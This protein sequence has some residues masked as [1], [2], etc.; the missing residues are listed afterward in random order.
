MKCVRQTVSACT[1]LSPTMRIQVIV[2]TCPVTHG[3]LLPT[4]QTNRRPLGMAPC[5]ADRHPHLTGCDQPQPQPQGQTNQSHPHP[6]PPHTPGIPLF[7]FTFHLP[8][9][10]GPGPVNHAGQDGNT[11]QNAAG[12]PPQGIPDFAQFLQQLMG[13]EGGPAMFPFGFHLPSFMHEEER[14]DPERATRLVNG[15]EIVP[16]GLVKRM[17]RV[18]G[19]GTSV[20]EAPVCAICWES[21][22]DPPGSD[23]APADQTESQASSE[24]SMNL[25]ESSAVPTNQPDSV[26]SSSE[27]NAVQDDRI[28]VLP[29]SHVFHASCLLPWFSKPHRTTCP[30]CRFDID[31]DSLTYVPRPR[32]SRRAAAGQAPTGPQ[33]QTTQAETGTQASPQPVPGFPLG[34]APGGAPDAG[35]GQDQNRAHRPPLSPF[36]AL[37]FSMFIPVGPIPPPPM[38]HGQAQAQPQPQARGQPQQPRAGPM[39]QFMRLDEQSTRALFDRIFGSGPQPQGQPAGAAPGAAVPPPARPMTAP[40]SPRPAGT[41]AAPPSRPTGTDN[42]APPQPGARREKRR[43]SLPAAPG[44]TLRQRI[45][46]REREMG[47]RCSDPT[48]GLGPSD[49]DPAPVVD[50]SALRQIH[51]RPL[52]GHGEGDR[53]CEHSF[54]PACLVRAERVAGWSPEDKK[55]NENEDEVEVSCPVCR[56][57][58]YISRED[59]EEGARALV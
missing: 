25:D 9:V 55:R 14:D 43:W 41:D 42:T 2:T 10:P 57:I 51:I 48:C 24:A 52:K 40:P 19:S 45:E 35:P 38:P 11:E 49:E 6:H 23:D 8:V 33:R 22:L 44:P 59:W 5:R 50:E 4:R 37:D 32:R 12:N 21:L 17:E 20:G 36:V 27:P 13:G 47:L 7:N 28:V 54:H 31:P 16:A 58:G 3:K 34:G 30:S 1:L 56:A 15:L 53:V 39:P 46:R 18:G 29:C 26:G